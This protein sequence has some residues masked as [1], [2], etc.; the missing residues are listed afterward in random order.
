MNDSDDPYQILGV[1]RNATLAEIK[2]AY[3]KL[4]LLHHPDRISEPSQQAQASVIFTRISN[5]YE[6]LSD[7][8]Q[9]REYDVSASRGGNNMP[10]GHD[11]FHAPQQ[12][13]TGG[14]W[15]SQHDPFAASSFFQRHSFHDPFSIFEQVFGEEFGGRRNSNNARRPGGMFGDPFFGGGMMDPFGA[16]PFF[17]R[18]GG[19]ASMMDPFGNRGG[20]M[21]GNMMMMDP[22][23]NMGG[24]GG[25]NNRNNSGNPGFTS[26]VSISSSTTT[27]TTGPRGESVTTQTTRKVVNGREETV[28]ERIVRQPDGSV[29]RQVLND[30][31][32]S[33]QQLEHGSGD[34]RSLRR[35]T[36]PIHIE[37][38]DDDVVEV[39]GDTRTS[40]GHKHGRRD[41]KSGVLKPLR[42]KHES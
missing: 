18:G 8:Q 1:S 13:S 4:A 37:S 19:G 28:T 26:S 17:S 11:P 42:K 2:T 36:T 23:G 27:N 9:R 7:E 5:A 16:D 29:T 25:M 14:N 3:R 24:G 21:F 20:S 40:T 41:S 33:R 32:S 22:F 10:F 34:R 35:M 30:G 15:Q 31:D 39:V 12:S 38:D 6:V